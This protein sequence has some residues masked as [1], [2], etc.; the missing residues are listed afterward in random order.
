MEEMILSPCEGI[1]VKIK[2][3]EERNKRCTTYFKIRK[4]DGTLTEMKKSYYGRVS[5]IEVKEGEEVVKGMVLAYVEEYA[6]EM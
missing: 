4:K 2:I 3:D 6:L 1:L 5:S